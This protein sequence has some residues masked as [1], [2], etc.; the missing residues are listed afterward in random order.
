MSAPRPSTASG[1]TR[2]LGALSL[3]GLALLLAYAL[4]WS[5][6]DAVQ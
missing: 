5:P 2:V 1:A 3:A 6:A 4:V